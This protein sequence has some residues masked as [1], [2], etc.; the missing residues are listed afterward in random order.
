MTSLRQSHV[1]TSHAF[2]EERPE[3]KRMRARVG[4]PPLCKAH[5]ESSDVVLQISQFIGLSGV[6][7]RTF[8][9]VLTCSPFHQE[10][11][12]LRLIVFS[13]VTVCTE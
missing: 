13:L 7:L 6:G 9:L 12:L 5:R 8:M 1:K 4:V 2:R 11:V 3:I 10:V